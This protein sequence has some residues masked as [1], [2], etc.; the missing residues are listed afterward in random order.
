MHMSDNY[1]RLRKNCTIKLKENEE[2]KTKQ[3]QR[4]DQR[5]KMKVVEDGRLMCKFLHLKFKPFLPLILCNT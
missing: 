5:T 4:E 2:N 3:D 1:D